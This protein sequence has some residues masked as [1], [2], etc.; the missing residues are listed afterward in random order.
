MICSST[1]RLPPPHIQG[2]IAFLKIQAFCKSKK[3][4]RCHLPGKITG[5]H[6]KL[7]LWVTAPHP[8]RLYTGNLL[9]RGTQCSQG[10][11]R[12]LRHLADTPRLLPF[13]NLPQAWLHGSFGILHIISKLLI[14]FATGP[15]SLSIPKYKPLVIF[16]FCKIRDKEQN[17][18]FS[19]PDSQIN[20][21][22][23]GNQNL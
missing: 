8:D 13:V 10:G 4:L 1:N 23:I 9:F 17:G 16:I 21:G 5:I 2:N 7:F 19:I 3:M 20:T 18:L 14:S 22:I 11:G 6:Q 15:G 12:P